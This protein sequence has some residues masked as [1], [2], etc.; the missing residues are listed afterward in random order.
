[1]IQIHTCAQG[2]PEWYAARA[3]K[4]TASELHTVLAKGKDGGSSVTRRAY[5]LRL[6]GEII[7]GQCAETYSNGHMERGKVMEEEARERYAFEHDAAPQ[8][9]GFI[10]NGRKG[11]SPDA[12]LDANGLLEIKTKE[13][14]RLIEC[15]LR[16]SFPPEHRAQCQG[17]LWVA[18]REWIDLAIY[19][20]GMPLVVHR[21]YRDEPYIVALTEAVDGFNIELDAI[22]TKVRVFG[23]SALRS[24]A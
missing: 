8:L 19:W 18:E 4:V 1:M 6:A 9:V 5:M 13:P 21:A 3:G 7:T 20:P 11:A 22:V 16:D 15:L 10:E 23:S 14:H 2:S 12:L 17:A 24:A